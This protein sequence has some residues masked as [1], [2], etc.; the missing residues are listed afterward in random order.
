MIIALD[1]RPVKG[2][3]D[4]LRLLDADRIDRTISVDILRR[5]EQ[6]RIWIGPTER[7]A[8]L[9]APSPRAAGRGLG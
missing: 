5:S 6:K 4:L 2:V 7:G 8:A 1:G 9:S 3:E